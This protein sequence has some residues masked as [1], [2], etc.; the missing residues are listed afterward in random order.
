MIL[1]A[2]NPAV[3]QENQEADPVEVVVAVVMAVVADE[4]VAV[5]VVAVNGNSMMPF[6][7]SAEPKRR[8]RLGQHQA[9]RY[10]AGIASVGKIP[11]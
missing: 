6:A 1:F 11:I 7:L 3:R 4:V 10:F 2:A 8:Y 5:A 9:N